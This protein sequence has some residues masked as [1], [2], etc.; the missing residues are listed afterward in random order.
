LYVT[1]VAGEASSDGRRGIAVSAGSEPDTG[2]TISTVK[3]EGFPLG[4]FPDAQY[5][6]ITLAAKPG[7]VLIFFSDGIVDAENADGEMFG[8]DRL[9]AVLR[10]QPSVCHSAQATVD[11]I[12]AAVAG[13][14]AGTAHFDDETLVVLRVL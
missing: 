8:T 14:Q 13:F 7:D 6:E 11:A 9:T 5:E 3:T 10:E 1:S 4:L 2:F 12:L